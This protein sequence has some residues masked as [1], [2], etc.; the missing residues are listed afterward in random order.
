MKTVYQADRAGW[1]VGLTMADESPLEPGVFHV[2]AMAS[3][4]APPPPEA[5]VDGTWPRLMPTGWVMQ[6]KPVADEMTAVEK[7]NAFLDANPDV[8]AMVRGASPPGPP[9][10]AT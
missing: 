4:E 2:P 5:W 7:L 3:E 1:F 6:L 10:S 9:A 8:A